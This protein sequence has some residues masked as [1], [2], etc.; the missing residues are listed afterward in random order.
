MAAGMMNQCEK[1][2][3]VIID[4]QRHARELLMDW[5]DSHKERS[6]VKI[7]PVKQVR[8]EPKQILHRS[9]K[10]EQD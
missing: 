4:V 6:K 2:T 7:S 5:R 8:M 9:P 3:I 1:K 10:Q